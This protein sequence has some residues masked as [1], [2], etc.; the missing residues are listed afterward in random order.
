MEE[1]YNREDT[2]H[3]DGEELYPIPGFPMYYANLDE[4]KIYSLYSNK[5][6]SNK[7]NKRFNYVYVGMKNE[8]GKWV[9][10][11]CHVA[12]WS[13][14][15]GRHYSTLKKAKLT[16]HHIDEDE[17]N[18]QATNLM[19]LKLKDNQALSRH[20]RKKTYRVLTKEEV[21][22]MRELWGF[23]GDYGV[24][25]S[26]MCNYISEEINVDYSTVER[27]LKGQSYRKFV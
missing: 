24:K 6:L 3:V 27:C 11:G 20:N 26:T 17:T 22:Q 1:N 23:F 2:I 14:Y 19:P 10:M 18:N 7:P 25:F 8:Q 13:A 16:L 12:I 21:L 9:H 5:Y 4:G 15:S